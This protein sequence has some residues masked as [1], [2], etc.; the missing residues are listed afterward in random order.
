M[1]EKKRMQGFSQVVLDY[2]DQ[3]KRSLPWRDRDNPYY[4][5][6]SEIMLQ[7]TRVEAVKDYFTRF[8]KALPDIESLAKCPEDDLLKLWQGLGYYNRARNLKTAA[9]QILENFG[10]SLPQTRAD[11]LTLAGIGPYTAGAIASIAFGQK[12]VAL[13]GN[14]IRVFA[15]LFMVEADFSKQAAKTDLENRIRPYLPEDRPGDFNQAIMDIGAGICIPKG[16]PLCH[17]CPITDYCLAYQNQVPDLYP[18]KKPKKPRKIEQYTIFILQKGDKILVRKRKKKGLLAGLWEFPNVPGH[19][20]MSQAKKELADRWLEPNL[21]LIKIEKF[22]PA[23][24]IFSHIEWEMT[25]YWVYL[26]EK[27]IGLVAEAGFY[28][29]GQVERPSK[30]SKL[31]QANPTSPGQVWAGKEEIEAY[32]SLPSAFKVYQASVLAQL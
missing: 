8:I 5:W 27:Q 14:L 23:K 22:L 2:Y 19:I 31:S 1:P 17:K 13:D 16:K 30:R 26:Q 24:H 9:G 12:E 20:S 11:L 28:P 25:S 18:L 4:T 21:D 32:L 3:D 29:W 15:R 7:Q 10:G 6:L